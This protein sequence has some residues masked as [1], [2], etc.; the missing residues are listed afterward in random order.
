MIHVK[1]FIAIL[2]HLCLILNKIN[3]A[4]LLKKISLTFQNKI[5]YNK[6][7]LRIF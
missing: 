3:N 2:Q 7:A 6:E 5:V 4:V 1:V